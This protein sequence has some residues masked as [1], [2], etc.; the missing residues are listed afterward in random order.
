MSSKHMMSWSDRFALIDALK[1]SE[2][3]TCAAFGLT[4]DELQTARQLRDA[5]TFKPTPNFD[6]TKY[7]DIFTA[8]GSATASSSPVATKGKTGTAATFTKPETASKKAKVP[9]KRGRKGDKIATAL[10]AVPT[11]QTPIDTFMTQHGV[12]LAVLRQSK[13]FLAKIDPAVAAKIGTIKV[14]QDK[15][16]KQLMIWRESN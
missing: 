11:S 13:R 12:S 4:A 5:G 2:A 14:R 8:S 3:Q 7:A 1:P 10:A 9:Q 6:V 16:T 15:A